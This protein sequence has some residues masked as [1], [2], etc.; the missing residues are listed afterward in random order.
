MDKKD[1]VQ[2]INKHPANA[3]QEQLNFGERAADRMTGF[4]GSWSFIIIF[5]LILIVWI[6]LNSLA[7][8]LH[9]DPYPFILLN[10]TL[11]CIAAL[12]A[13]VIMMSQKRQEQRDRI[14]AKYDYAINRKAERE[15]QDIQ[16]D[17]EEIK[18]LLKSQ[19]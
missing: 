6:T 10:L 4:L 3:L 16:R 2:K 15:I 11:S 12:Q 19:K 7:W 1:P 13:P 9:W 5:A 14:T 18:T 17:L 8:I